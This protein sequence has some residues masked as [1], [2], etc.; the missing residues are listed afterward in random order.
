[1]MNNHPAFTYQMASARGASPVGRIVC[2]YDTILRDF[3]RAQVAFEAGN[4]ETRVFELNHALTVIAHLQSALDRQRGGEAAK[5]FDRFYEVTRAMILGAN[6]RPTAESFQDL[7][8]LYSS[9]RQAWQEVE[10]KYPAGSQESPATPTVANAPAV[11]RMANLPDNA[12]DAP[13]G[14]WSA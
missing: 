2:L 5:R 10:Q 4:I 13:R 8:T 9:L 14:K 12:M 11:P 7:V 3:R 1:M 6:I